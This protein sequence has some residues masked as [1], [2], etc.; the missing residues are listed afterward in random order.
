MIEATATK[1]YLAK[2]SG[3]TTDGNEIATYSIPVAYRITVQP[4]S[5]YLDVQTYGTRVQKMYKA[6]IDSA[7]FKG[8]FC[9]GDK[10]YLEGATP[11]GETVN[12][13]NANYLVISVRPQYKAIQVYFEKLQIGE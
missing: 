4:V 6:V 11:T 5:G 7:R 10:A 12:G 2:K 9:E 1:I 13:Q 3:Y 8:I